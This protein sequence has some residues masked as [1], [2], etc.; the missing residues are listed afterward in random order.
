MR[1]VVFIRHG[2]AENGRDDFN[3]DL[4]SIGIL[5]ARKTAEEIKSKGLIPDL[6]IHSAALRTTK[7]ANII[8]E[9]FNLD[10]KFIIPYE[11]LYL[12]SSD[13]ILE[14]IKEQHQDFKIIFL[15]GHNPGISVLATRMLKDMS[16]SFLPADFVAVDYFR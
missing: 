5:E 2:S 13:K 6:I 7:T 11:E 12:A 16:I 1:K 9:I 4:A 8:S 10:Q 14:I 3:R 15:V